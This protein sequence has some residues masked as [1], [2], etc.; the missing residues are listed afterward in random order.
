M[1]VVQRLYHI[2][3]VP[4]HLAA[5]H[6]V[7]YQPQASPAWRCDSIQPFLPD[8]RMVSSVAGGAHTLP[9]SSS[10]ATPRPRYARISAPARQPLWYQRIR[11]IIRRLTIGLGGGYQS[12]NPR[13]LRPEIYTCRYTASLSLSLCWVPAT[14]FCSF[15]VNSSL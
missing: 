9:F 3:R 7:P 15:H 1:V 12:N 8:A 6:R 5:S 11:A 14:P 13:N 4:L 2:I 10:G